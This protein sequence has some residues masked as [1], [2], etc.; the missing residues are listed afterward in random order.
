MHK[1][2]SDKV[3]KLLYIFITKKKNVF[4]YFCFRKQLARV[5]Q[6]WAPF[7]YDIG[8]RAAS[9]YFILFTMFSASREAEARLAVFYVAVCTSL[10][11]PECIWHFYIFLLLSSASFIF[12]DND[13]K[14]NSDWSPKRSSRLR[15][16]ERAPAQPVTTQK[17]GSG[18]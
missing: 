18:A 12:C 16:F 13:S 1:Y 7:G 11:S 5:F 15:F 17:Y 8:R 10:E 4:S 6:A 3:M 2:I 14:T 9:R